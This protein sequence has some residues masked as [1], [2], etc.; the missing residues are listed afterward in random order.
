VLSAGAFRT[1]GLSGYAAGWFTGGRLTWLSGANA[2]LFCEVRG[3]AR[4]GP[5]APATLDLWQP[6][7]E[8]IAP[9]DAFAVAAGCDKTVTT[10]GAKFDN[11]VNFRGFPHMPGNDYV[12]GYAQG[13]AGND[14][15][16]LA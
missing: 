15:G 5:L 1:G 3:H 11:A 13:G 2:G 10:C 14:G 16:R 12:T 4:P 9:G 7:P 8:P 6:L